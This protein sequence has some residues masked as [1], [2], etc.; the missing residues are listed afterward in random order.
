LLSQRMLHSLLRTLAQ[1]GGTASVSRLF[2]SQTVPFRALEVRYHVV[3]TQGIHLTPII[4]AFQLHAGFYCPGG[5]AGEYFIC[6]AGFYCPTPAQQIKCPSG[7]YCPSGSPQPYGTSS[8]LLACSERFGFTPCFCTRRLHASVTMSRGV[9]AAALGSAVNSS[10][11]RVC[12]YVHCVQTIQ[13]VSSQDYSTQ[14][15][16]RFTP[17]TTTCGCQR[18]RGKRFP[19]Q[20]TSIWRSGR[21]A[22][23]WC[24]CVCVCVCV[25]VL[26]HCAC[27]VNSP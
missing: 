21:V 15:P 9:V 22:I 5:P 12:R 19:A 23:R 6:K 1:P 26:Q 25:F 11:H 8:H 16:E 13:R 3:C 4:D 24:V 17:S 7:K 14:H 10:N 18:W 20:G 2:R 27:I